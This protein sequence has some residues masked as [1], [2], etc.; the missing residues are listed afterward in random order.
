MFSVIYTEFDNSPKKLLINYLDYS[1]FSLFSKTLNEVEDTLLYIKLS[2]GD[3]KLD[4]E[5]LS[6][7]YN[8]YIKLFL[9]LIDFLM[10]L[11]IYL[12]SSS[13]TSNYI[14]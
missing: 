4:E 11:Y 2:I 8:N 3:T 6:K 12:E 9:K 10:Y 1:G 5:L 7:L 13:I 14:L